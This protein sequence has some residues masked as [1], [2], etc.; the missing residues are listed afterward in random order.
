MNGLAVVH[1]TAWLRYRYI[2][3]LTKCDCNS[4]VH[5]TCLQTGYLSIVEKPYCIECMGFILSNSKSQKRFTVA[6]VV[7]LQLFA[8]HFIVLTNSNVPYKQIRKKGLIK[9]STISYPGL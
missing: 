8:S 5:C 3:F 4:S 9:Y 7:L 1:S 2:F 6:L